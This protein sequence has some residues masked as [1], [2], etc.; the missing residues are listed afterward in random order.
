MD[1][2]TREFPFEDYI[3]IIEMYF[4]EKDSSVREISLFVNKGEIVECRKYL[5]SKC[6]K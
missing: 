4:E 3:D 5:L 2:C 1:Y 6:C